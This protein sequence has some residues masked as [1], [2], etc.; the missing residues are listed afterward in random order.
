[1]ASSAATS[2][3]ASTKVEPKQA[4]LNSAEENPT[5][6]KSADAKP[7]GA[8]IYSLD[9]LRGI[10]IIAMCYSGVIGGTRGLP[11][12]MFHAQYP[13]PA[14]RYDASVP[15]YTWVD[16]VFPA[17][18]FSMGCAMP[19]AMGRRL[20]KGKGVFPSI[21]GALW[22]MLLL[23]FFGVYV[24][25]LQPY[26]MQNPPSN[27][28]WLFAF[29]GF[30]SL[31]PVFAILPKSWSNTKQL[32]VRFLGFLFAFLLMGISVIN[33]TAGVDLGI[34]G[35][36]NY[37]GENFGEILS[38][39]IKKSDI[40]IIVLSNMAFFAATI[41][42]LTRGNL[43]HRIACMVFVF[44]LWRTSGFGEAWTA[45][46]LR[47]SITVFSK[48]VDISWFYRFD[49]LKY[50][51]V[52]V[53]GTIIGDCLY[54]WVKKKNRDSAGGIATK[55]ACM[56]RLIAVS[57]L[58]L[59]LL[60]GCMTF[61]HGRQEVL[62]TLLGV[63]WNYLNTTPYFCAL[64]IAAI[65]A[66]L[67]KQET[68]EGA[69]LH[70][71]LGWAAFWLFLG[72]VFEPLKGGIKKDPSDVT[73]YFVSTGLSIYLLVF[74]YVWVDVLKVKPGFNLLVLNGQNP[75]LSYFGIRNLLGPIMMC[76]IIWVADQNGNIEILSINAI[77]V[78]WIT[79]YSAEANEWV[80]PW[81]LALWG[82]IKTLFLAVIVAELTKRKVI[83]KS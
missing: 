2:T 6:A 75:L 38:Q 20:E 14:L 13:P 67:P 82:F 11:S 17:F 18:L 5:N 41:W 33:R 21:L 73:Y 60:I 3:A 71:L 81:S 53:P 49:F 45:P 64:M 63:D 22:R 83:W 55:Q 68:S 70:K 48:E 61:L 35:T 27:A 9:A 62:F 58:S 8:R 39:M 31:F 56:K 15:G 74:F 40:I 7:A 46:Y 34:V 54:D 23:V 4:V 59:L 51:L 66:L 47:S 79:E 80:R 29:I 37:F 65:Y 77:V 57:L 32:S 12:W 19:F 28:T 36:L 76:G 25:N 50:L 30:V 52:V 78:G 42:I 26:V 16:L 1:M 72:L 44:A 43:L 69:L 24:Q 10:A